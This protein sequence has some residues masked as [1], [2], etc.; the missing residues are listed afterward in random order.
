M[1][2]AIQPTPIGRE[3]SFRLIRYAQPTETC[4][5]VLSTENPAH[6]LH[7]HIP[8]THT[9]TPHTP[10][11]YT[12]TPLQSYIHTYDSVDSGRLNTCT[13]YICAS[14]KGHHD[15]VQTLLGASA[16][17]NIARSNVNDVYKKRSTAE[18]IHVTQRN[19]QPRLG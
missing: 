2:R 6:T 16:G 10:H 4:I 3:L 12:H 11:T 7:T 17:V 13:K 15:V 14:Q 19:I 18:P 9:H 8:H 1:S 5:Y